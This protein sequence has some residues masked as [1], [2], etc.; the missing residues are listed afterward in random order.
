MTQINSIVRR[1]PA[2]SLLTALALTLPLAGYEEPA[3]DK[4]ASQDAPKE[5][6]KPA[7]AAS[8]EVHFTDGSNL[9][10]KLRDEK[11]ELLTP[12]GKLL[13]PVGEVKKIDFATRIPDDVLKKVEA[14][15]ADLG[16]ADYKTREAASAQLRAL[17]AAA[18]AAVEKA[19][20]SSDAEVAKRAGELLAVIRE[21]VGEER[22][23][24]R[25]FD[26][27]TTEHS[28]IAGRIQGGALKVTTAQFGDQPMK[29]SDVRSLGVPGTEAEDTAAAGVESG[30]ANLMALQGSIGK[31]F[32]FRVTGNVAGSLWGTDVYTTDSSLETAAVHAGVLKPG[33]TGVVKVTI[34][35]PPPFFTGTTRNGVTSQPY[36]GFP[37]AFKVSK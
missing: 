11:I 4:P 23:E 19:A 16:S 32:R 24:I 12:Y 7:D 14:A 6:A 10:V 15:V 22:L 27:V 37:G 2:V 20:K 34:L 21:E 17:G 31:T 33:Q 28:K 3:P 25:P 9:K 5:K 29:L 1:R 8:V 26:V 35:A 30:P 36:A 13:I 18:Y